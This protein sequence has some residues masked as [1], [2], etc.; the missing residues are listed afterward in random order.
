LNR[1]RQ[2]ISK[3]EYAKTTFAILNRVP[4]NHHHVMPMLYVREIHQTVA[5][6]VA[7]VRGAGWAMARNVSCTILL[8]AMFIR[9]SKGHIHAMPMQNV[10][11]VNSPKV[12]DHTTVTASH[13]TS[14]M[15]IHVNFSQ[16]N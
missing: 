10:L 9:V 16:S 15:E 5:P 11:K 14:V 12:A 7:I 1:K 13:P 8:R 2:Q 6:T 4:D 3:I